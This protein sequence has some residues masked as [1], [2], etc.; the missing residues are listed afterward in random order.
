MLD[1]KIRTIVTQDAEVDD[2]NSF[3][4]LLLYAND[5]EIQGIIH[6]FRFFIGKGKR[7]KNT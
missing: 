5:I 6:I 4:H 3:R 1:Y 7:C 2:Q